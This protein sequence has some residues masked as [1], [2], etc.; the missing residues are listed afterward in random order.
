M[1]YILIH[2]LNID[3][4]F[5]WNFLYQNVLVG[6]LLLLMKDNESKIRC[7]KCYI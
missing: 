1:A 7:F 6:A 2:F 5:D 3:F 4:I